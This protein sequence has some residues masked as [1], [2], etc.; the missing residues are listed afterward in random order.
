MIMGEN[1]SRRCRMTKR[2]IARAIRLL[3]QKGRVVTGTIVDERARRK[4]TA[5]CTDGNGIKQPF[6][7]PRVFG[8]MYEV[9]QYINPD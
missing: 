7:T 9:E 5:I 8:S 3:A 6:G 1:K 2:E 4:V